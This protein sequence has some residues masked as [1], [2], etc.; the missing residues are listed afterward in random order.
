MNKSVVNKVLVFDT[1]TTGIPNKNTNDLS[2]QPYITQI[3]F[4]IYDMSIDEIVFEYSSYIKIGTDI[5]ISNKVTELTGITNKKCQDN[6]LDINDVLDLFIKSYNSNDI[7]MVV[8]HNIDFDIKMIEIECL[9]NNKEFVLPN[10]IHFCTMRNSVFISVDFRKKFP[11]LSEL[12]TFLFGEPA[13]MNL[14][15]SKVDTLICMK[16]FVKMREIIENKTK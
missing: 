6:G 7:D 12:Y 1:E 5:E 8:A 11:K 16:C 10:K 13:P 15:N 14:H 2:K 3:S 9:R 4:V